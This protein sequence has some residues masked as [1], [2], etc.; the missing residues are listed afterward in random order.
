MACEQFL[1]NLAGRFAEPLTL[2]DSGP[3]PAVPAAADPR[4]RAREGLVHVL[5]NH[6][7]FVTIR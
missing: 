4:Q 7:D 1:N 5:F 6:N 3:A 2:F